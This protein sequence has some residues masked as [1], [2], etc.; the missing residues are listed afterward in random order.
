MNVFL[1]VSNTHLYIK[2]NEI[3]Q[4]FFLKI[5]YYIVCNMIEHAY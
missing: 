2:Q 4:E 1:K 5:T 3:K